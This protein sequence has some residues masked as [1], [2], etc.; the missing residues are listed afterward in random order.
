V[1]YSAFLTLQ[2][3][4][5]R[6]GCRLE[7]DGTLEVSRVATLEAAQPGDVAFLANRK[8]LA[9]VASTRASAVIAGDDLLTAPCAIL[10]A[11]DSYL[12]FTAAV[13]LFA[14]DERPS[15]GVSD[16]AFVAPDAVL[17]PE[18][19]VGAFAW[20]GA[21][22][23]I[24][25]RSVVHPHA[26]IYPGAVLGEDCT[27]HAQVSIRERCRLGDRVILQ[28]GAVIGGDGY[29]FAPRPDGTYQKIPPVAIVVIEDDVEVGANSTIDRPAVGE[30]RI[31]AGTKIDN[32]VMVAHGVHVGRNVMLVA[33]VGVSGSTTIG[34]SV[35]LAGQVGVAGHLH[36]GKGTRA[37]AQTGIPNSLPD[38]SLVSG[39]PAIDNRDWLKASAVFR[40]L[41]ELKKAVSA[42]ER[43]LAELEG[44]TADKTP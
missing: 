31:G 10:R 8:Y 13:G 3:L 9:Q 41:P 6:L 23:R 7:G 28:N 14:P 15:P 16:L 25:A 21:G 20:I 35:I 42:L 39:Y 33:Q 11:H 1:I 12:A 37:T 5:D 38:G 40:R 44:R 18:V 2:E 24:G 32:L 36:I 43:R 19:H 22:V 26:T 29:G 34:D 27:V 30:T 4:A 17:G